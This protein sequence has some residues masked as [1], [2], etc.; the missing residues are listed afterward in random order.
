MWLDN[1][2]QR[3]LEKLIKPNQFLT[4]NTAEG[5]RVTLTSSMQICCY[6]QEKYNMS[7]ILTGKINQDSLEVMYILY[8]L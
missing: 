5:L 1:W 3:V 7:Y 2:E 8:N 4:N 6:M